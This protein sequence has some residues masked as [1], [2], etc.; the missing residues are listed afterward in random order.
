MPVNERS[1]RRE[2]RNPVLALPAHK[3][4]MALQPA[5]KDALRDTLLD[6]RADVKLPT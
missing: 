6:L 5:Q 2:V 4:L 3:K 1:N